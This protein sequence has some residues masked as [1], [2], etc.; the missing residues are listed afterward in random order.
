M[1]SNLETT[2]VILGI[3]AAVSVLQGIALVAMCVAGYK[4]YRRL[5]AFGD[6]VEA[7]HVAPTVAR[8]HALMDQVEPIIEDLRQV[9]LRVR[10]ETE[11]VDRAIHTTIQGVDRAVG[12]VRTN[13]R[14][15][16]RWIVGLARG[17]RVAL[18]TILDPRM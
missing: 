13:V 18:E 6:S 4:G 9:S 11:R 3:M 16:A 12:L 5:M 1:E 10:G 15:R 17:A 14:T 7:E 8:M 2:N